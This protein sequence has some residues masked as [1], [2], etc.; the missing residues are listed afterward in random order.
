MESELMTLNA[1][2]RITLSINLLR[3]LK[4]IHDD[5]ELIHLDL[6]LDNILVN[7]E[8]LE[9]TI[10]DFS[11]SKRI[12]QKDIGS[13]ISGHIDYTS[14]EEVDHEKNI[15]KVNTDKKTDIYAMGKIIRAIWGDNEILSLYINKLDK[16]NSAEDLLNRGMQ[17]LDNDGHKVK[18][19]TALDGMLASIKPP[20]PKRLSTEDVL[21]AFKEVS[22]ARGNN[23]I[24]QVSFERFKQAYLTEYQKTFFLFR[25]PFSTMHKM[26]TS[27]NKNNRFKTIEQVEAHVSKKLKSRTARVLARL[28]KS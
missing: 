10:I 2:Q 6:K 22:L 20:N 18:L 8:T 25:N 28:K 1:D 3:A 26:L 24:E 13:T 12:G 4:A 19:R 27:G 11:N 15:Y 16:P 7:P 23:N 5:L 21:T 9:V 14:T 17:E